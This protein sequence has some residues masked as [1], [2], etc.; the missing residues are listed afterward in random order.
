MSDDE[1]PCCGLRW[2]VW[3]GG[4]ETYSAWHTAQAHTHCG[5]SAGLTAVECCA[6]LHSYEALLGNLAGTPGLF[7]LSWHTPHAGSHLLAYTHLYYLHTRQHTAA[8]YAN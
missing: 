4:S 7:I 3:D 1:G 2:G 5:F 6:A 8:Y